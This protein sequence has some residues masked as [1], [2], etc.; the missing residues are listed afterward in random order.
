MRLLF[1]LLAALVILAVSCGSDADDSLSDPVSLARIRMGEKVDG[2]C[3]FRD[4]LSQ[5]PGTYSGV[6]E[7][8]LQAVSIGPISLAE[9]EQMKRDKPSFWENS[10]PYQQ[11]LV[12]EWIDDKCDFSSPAVQAY[13]EFSETVSTDRT[14]CVMIVDVGPVTEKQIAKVQRF[15]T[16][17]SETPVSA[18]FVP[19]PGQ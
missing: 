1:G 11:A 3:I 10:F 4:D 17:S 8:C 18:L 6:S 14:N 2:Q 13:L 12:G 7:D 15:G 9:L 16:M 5:Y 19:A